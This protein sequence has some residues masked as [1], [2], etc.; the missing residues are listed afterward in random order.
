[1]L[2]PALEPALEAALEPALEPAPTRELEAAVAADALPRPHAIPNPIPTLAPSAAP[3]SCVWMSES[4]V[5][6][7]VSRQGRLV[8]A[9]DVIPQSCEEISDGATSVA[10]TVP[11]NAPMSA[12]ARSSRR[13]AMR[14]VV[15]RPAARYVRGRNA[16]DAELMQ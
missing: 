6:V 13:V 4:I 1:M 7:T 8:M 9:S 3:M 15:A 2:E 12:V 16:S 10:S 11:R 14:E 5:R